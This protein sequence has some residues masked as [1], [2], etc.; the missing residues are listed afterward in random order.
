L[1]STLES[2]LA[3]SSAAS[4]LILLTYAFISSEALASKFA[5]II[6]VAGTS[7]ETLLEIAIIGLMALLKALGSTAEMSSLLVSRSIFFLDVFNPEAAFIF[8]I[9][10]IDF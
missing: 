4:A 6:S 8:C 2:S 3:R 9:C 7:E 10:F 5:S 1:A